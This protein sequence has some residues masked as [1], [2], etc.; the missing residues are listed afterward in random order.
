MV[1]QSNFQKLLKDIE[2]SES[3]KT[4]AQSAHKTL[5]SFLEDHETFKEY[6]VKT[7][8]SGSYKRD[9]AIRPRTKEG[10]TERPD[11]DII[12]VTNHTLKDKPQEVIT[13]LYNTLKGKYPDIRK[14]SRSVGITT[15]TVDMDVVPIIAP[16]GTE[17]TLYIPDKKLNCWLKTNP[18]GHT[19]WT[20]KVNTN[21]NGLFKPTVKLFKWWRRENP[22]IDKKPKGFVLECIAA[23]CMD[24]NLSQYPELFIGMFDKI[25]S[26]Y[27]TD[28][29]LG[30]VPY[31]SDPSVQG[32]NVTDG[33]SFAAFEGF[34]NKIKKHAEIGR[35]AIIEKDENLSLELW[36]KIFGDRFASSCNT[37]CLLAEAYVPSL[38]FPNKPIQPKKPGGFA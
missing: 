36:C 29:L 1:G 15:S 21:F 19:E 16:F 7:F 8:L 17:S 10:E 23:E 30:N 35:Q 20:T 22:T 31:I 33:M 37:S 4:S 32:N 25:V 14:Q 6:H 11:I 2:P 18:P 13:L 9:T 28:I 3:T 12:V 5:R 24:L 27:S 38:S 26:K 34:Y